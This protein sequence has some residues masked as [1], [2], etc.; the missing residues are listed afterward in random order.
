MKIT[1]DLYLLHHMYEKHGYNTAHFGELVEELEGIMSKPQI[2]GAL[3]TIG[4]W[5]LLEWEYGETKPGQAGRL[6][7]LDPKYATRYLFESKPLNLAE[8]EVG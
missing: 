2:L 4:D 5:G 8:C 7:R 3:N 1:P 6:Y